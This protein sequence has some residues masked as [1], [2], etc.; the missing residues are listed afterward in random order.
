M[1]SQPGI[2]KK[3]DIVPAA[4]EIPMGVTL[5]TSHL[6]AG[7]ML[8]LG[9]STDFVHSVKVAVI[10]VCNCPLCLSTLISS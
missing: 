2:P 3:T 7:M 4:Y 1:V 9:F 10:S 6:Y 8:A 5:L